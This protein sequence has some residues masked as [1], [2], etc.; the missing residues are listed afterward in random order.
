M[1]TPS[2]RSVLSTCALLLVALLLVGSPG[3]A[4]AA[5]GGKGGGNGGGSTSTGDGGT[6][7]GK[8]CT[9][10]DTT[11][12]TLRILAPTEG[13]VVS[14]HVDVAAEAG[15]DTGVAAVSGTVGAVTGDL[16]RGTSTWAGRL[17]TSSLPAGSHVLTVTASDQAGNATSATVVVVVDRAEPDTTAPSLTVSAPSAGATV[18]AGTV[19]ASG[20][21]SDDGGVARVEVRVDGGAPVVADGTA[22]WSASLSLTAGD[23]VLAVTATDASGNSAT[24]EVPVTAQD[25]ASPAD[26]FD[27]VVRDPAAS[28][29]LTSLA[30]S[31]LV[32]HGD[33]TGVL[34]RDG[35]KAPSIQLRSDAAATS[36]LRLPL[37]AADGWLAADVAWPTPTDLFV[38]GGFGPIVVRHYSVRWS[39]GVPVE[40]S[41]VGRRTFGDGDSRPGALTATSSG[42]VVLAW[43]QHGATGPQGQHVA[44]RRTAAQAWSTIG[45]LTFIPTNTTDQV[46]VEHP[47]D[48][49]LWLLSNPDAWGAIGR[50]RLTWS[51][52]A[53]V[54]AETDPYF[55]SISEHGDVGPDGEDPDLAVVADPA[56]GRVLLAYQSNDRRMFQ[57]DAGLRIE[58]R[59][60]VVSLAVDGTPSF[61]LTPDRSERVAPIALGVRPDGAAV[62]AYHPVDPTTG[63]FAA[64]VTRTLT[65]GGW[66]TARAL[67][68]AYRPLGSTAGGDLSV[69]VGGD[70]RLLRV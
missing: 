54:V 23:H 43:H 27:F 36:V 37:D 13:A 66:T 19:T 52:D 53:L 20:S 47:A 3:I 51:G 42:G 70:I 67:G 40:A 15:D 58:S 17:D 6:C 39:D 8:R 16:A 1:P 41:L 21:A 9:P 24:T 56:R 59:V 34:Y 55:L 49:S 4:D 32:T 61:A 7:K 62:V 35:T 68:E 25:A 64:V 69:Q 12:P 10:S 45:P 18:A 28:G 44:Y 48:G 57:T 33:L 14:D 30:V 5:P 50:A 65:S 38:S 26:P 22:S 29:T 46:L 2:R 63:D 60:A 31:D 11:A